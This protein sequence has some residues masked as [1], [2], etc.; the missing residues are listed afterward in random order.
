[1]KIGYARV[2][3]AQQDLT[4]QIEALKQAGCERIFAEKLSGASRNR[5]KLNQMLKSLT[6]GDEVIICRL[7]RLRRSLKDLL[8]ITDDISQAGA[9]FRSLG[10]PWADTTSTMGNVILSLFAGL[11]ELEREWIQERTTAGRKAAIERGVKMGRKPSLNDVQ[12]SEVK[13]MREQGRDVKAMAELFKVGKS[14][15]YRIL[16]S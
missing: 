12:K 10:E 6:H 3:T 14:T 8:N 11:S 7:S 9:K 4:L 15:I 16:E 2:S 1:M 13:R 5:P